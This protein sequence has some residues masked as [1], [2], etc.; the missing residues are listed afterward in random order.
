M[1]GIFF[2]I[3]DTLYSRQD[4]LLEAAHR[5]ASAEDFSNDRFMEIFTVK[6]DETLGFVEKGEM[7][8]YESNLFRFEETY[9]ELGISDAP[10]RASQA[11]KLYTD[12]QNHITL[13]P[14]L[15]EMFD[16]LSAREDLLLGICSNGAS[17]H[18]WRKVEMLNLSRWISREHVYVSGDL[19]FTKPDLAFFRQVEERE[20]LAPEN[21]W[22]VGDSLRCDILGAH[23]AGWKTVWVK[24]REMACSV[25][26]NAIVRDGKELAAWMIRQLDLL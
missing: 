18:Q 11:V 20:K 21:L 10:S 6:S 16:L 3:D 25:S 4:L 13:S 12:L 26:P 5:S 17:G 22:M 23:A 24:R 14:E 1:T 8:A 19:G 2:D 15:T 9:R 7:T